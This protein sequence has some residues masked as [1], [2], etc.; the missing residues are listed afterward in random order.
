MA[1]EMGYGFL[2]DPD[3]KLLSIGYRVPEGTLDPSCY[4]LLASEARLASFIAIAKGDVPARHWFHLGR[5]VTPIAYWRRADLLV[6]IDVRIPDALA[7]H[8]RAG[9]KPAG[10]DQPADRAAA[11]RLW[12]VTRPALGRLGVRLQHPRP[13]ADLPI[14][15]LRRP[16][17]RAEARPGRERRGG[18]VCN[19][20]CQHGRSGRGGTQL[21]AG[22]P[23]SAHAAATGSTRR[24]T[25]RRADCRRTQ[26]SRSCVPSWRT[27]R[28]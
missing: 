13:G 5:A 20:A 27:I 6:G 25:I 18:A 4:D 28:A 23:A 8:A 22:L 3:R 7:G 14:L 24:W 17:P 2:L 9:G 12:H 21:C 16:R 1:L 19:G 10:A 26:A 15:E 11:D